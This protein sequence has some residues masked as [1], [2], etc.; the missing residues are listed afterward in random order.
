ML[1][2]DSLSFKHQGFLHSCLRRDT[3]ETG[4]NLPVK[5]ILFLFSLIF[6]LEDFMS[7]SSFLVRG[8]CI[9]NLCSRVKRSF[10]VSQPAQACLNH[11]FGLFLGFLCHCSRSHKCCLYHPTRDR[12]AVIAACSLGPV[13]GH[14]QGRSRDDRAWG[15]MVGHAYSFSNVGA[16]GSNPVRSFGSCF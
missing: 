6:V 8:S 7:F 10:G 14:P 11:D 12:A 13:A 15:S 2:G 1:C 5:K 4:L 16:V 3:Q 9:S